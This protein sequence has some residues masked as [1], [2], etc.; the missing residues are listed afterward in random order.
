MRLSPGHAVLLAASLA[1]A[2]S[3]EAPVTAEELER[4]T[5]YFP[6]QFKYVEEPRFCF[7]RAERERALKEYKQVGA[8]TLFEVIIDNEGTV[9]KVRLLR[10]HV[11]KD[12][13]DF[14]LEH[15][16]WFLFTEDPGSEMYRAF[17]YPIVYDFEAEFEWL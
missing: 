12:Y 2:T 16:R 17:Y 11:R 6:P 7:T 8:D 14:M 13:H 15:A 9:K 1:L 4:A 10:T 3:C 5:L